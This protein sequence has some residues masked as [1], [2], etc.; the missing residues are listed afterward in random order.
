M[1][2]ISVVVFFLALTF[3]LGGSW[4]AAEIENP[5]LKEN[6]IQLRAERLAQ[7]SREALVWNE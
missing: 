6:L 7:A 2:T 3:T 4:A 1:K 5:K